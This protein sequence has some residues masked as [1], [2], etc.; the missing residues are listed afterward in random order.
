M[1]YCVYFSLKNR[2]ASDKSE[3][4]PTRCDAKKFLQTVPHG[5]ILSYSKK[6]V[7]ILGYKDFEPSQEENVKINSILD[8]WE[9]FKSL[10]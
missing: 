4:F 2:N 1:L 10:G 6:G 8:S 9:I 7:D 3:A 5:Y